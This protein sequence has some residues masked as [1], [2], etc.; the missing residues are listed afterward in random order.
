MSAAIR[1][2]FTQ[3]QIL[4]TDGLVLTGLI[5]DQTPTTVTLRGANNETTLVNRDDIE[6][7][8]AM[9]KSI[10]PDGVVD[11][12]SDEELRDLFAYV[13]ARTPPQ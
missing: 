13:I 2:E 5:D 3:Y 12:L 1:E 9:D 6:I 7:L 8:Q 4:T 10:M 11:K